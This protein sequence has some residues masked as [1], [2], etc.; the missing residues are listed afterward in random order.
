[1]PLRGTLFEKGGKIPLRETI[2][3]KAGKQE[4]CI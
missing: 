3:E 2:F 4:K 1:M